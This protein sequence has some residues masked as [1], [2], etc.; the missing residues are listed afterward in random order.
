MP[1][2]CFADT[3]GKRDISHNDPSPK[4]S[5]SESRPVAISTTQSRPMAGHKSQRRNP[6]PISPTPEAA[7]AVAVVGADKQA[8]EDCSFVRTEAAPESGQGGCEETSPLS[9]ADLFITVRDAGGKIVRS[10]DGYAVQGMENPLLTPA[11]LTA[12]VAHRS[13]LDSIMPSTPPSGGVKPYPSPTPTSD[14]EP[15]PRCSCGALVERPGDEI[16]SSCFQAELA[17]LC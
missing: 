15:L 9:L 8:T 16:C 10:D 13:E 4:S 2:S 5:P 6:H 3:S 12:L 1:P 11:I 17:A 7:Q 14:A